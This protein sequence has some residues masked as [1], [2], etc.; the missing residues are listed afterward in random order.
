[1]RLA[2]TVIKLQQYCGILNV[3][4]MRRPH[5]GKSPKQGNVKVSNNFAPVA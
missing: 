3:V 2:L 1:M 4:V 5:D